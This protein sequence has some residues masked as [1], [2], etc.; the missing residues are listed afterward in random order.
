MI[1]YETEAN[2]WPVFVRDIARDKSGFLRAYGHGLVVGRRTMRG[3]FVLSYDVR[4]DDGAIRQYTPDQFWSPE[5]I[6]RRMVGP[7]PLHIPAPPAYGA[8]IC[9]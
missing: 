3:K 5:N 8:R 7:S 6:G 4:M 9:P 1:S 2:P